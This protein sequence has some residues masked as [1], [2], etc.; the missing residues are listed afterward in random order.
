MRIAVLGAA[1]YL[2]AAGRQTMSLL[3]EQGETTLLLDAGSG[4]A[5]LLEPAVRALLPPG[6]RLDVLLTH[7]HLDHVVGLSYL[8]GLANDRPVRIHAPQPPLT[9]FG[10]EALD[11]LLAKPL[12]PVPI[13]RWPMPTEVVA[14]AGPELAI[15]ELAIRVRAQRHPGG[16][17]GVRLGDTLAYVTDTV[18]DPATAEFA[19][20]VRLLLHEVW[21]SEEEGARDDAARTGHSDAAQVADLARE[22]RVERLWLV[23]HHPRRSAQELAA[24]AGRMTARAGLPCEVPEEGRVYELG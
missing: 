17:T 2:P 5:R 8:P 23:H 1:G 19:R 24:M 21:L 4:V 14:F 10:P 18:M 20:G 3:L 7:Y 9:E 16:S 11:R 13:A 22:A 6:R 15:G 12:F